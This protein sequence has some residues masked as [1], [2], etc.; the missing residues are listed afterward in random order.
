M[1][2]LVVDLPTPT[3][4]ND[5]VKVSWDDYSIPNMMGKSESSHVPNHQPEQR[6]ETCAVQSLGKKWAKPAIMKKTSLELLSFCP[7]DLDTLFNWV[8]SEP[9]PD[10]IILRYSEHFE[11]VMQ[12][13]HCKLMW[14]SMLLGKQTGLTENSRVKVNLTVDH[15]FPH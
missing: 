5:G 8:C 11:P 12:V 15:H 9:I 6:F 10:L 1:T 3:W 14:H 2:W 7:L 4:K 13:N